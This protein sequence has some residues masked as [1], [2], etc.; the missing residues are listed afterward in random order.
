MN[1]INNFYK[2]SF[3]K[4]TKFCHSLWIE[5]SHIQRNF[6]Y[7]WKTPNITS[8]VVCNDSTIC[9]T[10]FN[11]MLTNLDVVFLHEIKPFI[12][13]FR[14][15]PKLASIF[16]AFFIKL[17]QAESLAHTCHRWCCSPWTRL[18]LYPNQDQRQ[19]FSTERAQFLPW[20]HYVDSYWSN[21]TLGPISMM[22]ATT[23][24]W[25]YMLNWTLSL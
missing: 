14:K 11:V 4:I 6:F 8:I 2:T 22:W 16:A 17:V 7:M 24:Y 12:S 25:T 9:E 13:G 3:E 15:E 5:K 1:T 10:L 18:H 23:F 21:I 19:T 20:N